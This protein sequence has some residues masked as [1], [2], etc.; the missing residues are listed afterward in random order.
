[1]YVVDNCY[2][3]L[4]AIGQIQS[5]LNDR[6]VSEALE[7]ARGVHKTGLSKDKF[8]AVSSDFCMCDVFTSYK[9]YCCV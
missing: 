9:N 3:D 7:L 5:L 4:C 6:R 2:I 8:T 1:M